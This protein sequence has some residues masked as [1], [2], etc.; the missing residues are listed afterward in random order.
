MTLLR[1]S[2]HVGNKKPVAVDMGVLGLTAGFAALIALAVVVQPY[3]RS[4]DKR[5]AAS[6]TR[7]RGATG[8]ASRR[9]ADGADR[10]RP[11]PGAIVAPRIEVRQPRFI[12][13]P[14]PPPADTGSRFEAFDE[15][16]RMDRLVRQLREYAAQA[17]P[18]DP[19]AS[20]EEDIEA[21]RQHGAPVIW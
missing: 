3:F 8:E 19:A 18:D 9:V 21:L 7:A 6:E 17:G 1:P 15:A 4:D 10:D 20:S 5:E 16:E 11:T 13:R 2:K 14:P 12:E